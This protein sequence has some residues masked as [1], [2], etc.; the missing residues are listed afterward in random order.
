MLLVLVDVSEDVGELKEC[1]GGSEVVSDVKSCSWEA[2]FVVVDWLGVSMAVKTDI[3]SV[4]EGVLTECVS[5]ED[6]KGC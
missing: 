5:V 1:I 6:I 3:E 4:A 2:E